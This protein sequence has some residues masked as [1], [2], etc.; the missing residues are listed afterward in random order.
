MTLYMVLPNLSIPPDLVRLVKIQAD[1]KGAATHVRPATSSAETILIKDFHSIESHP[2]SQRVRRCSD[3][4][5]LLA[6]V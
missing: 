5:A 3:K 1:A 6:E 2:T 4:R